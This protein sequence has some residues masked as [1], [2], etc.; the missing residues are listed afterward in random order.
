LDL[1]SIAATHDSAK[2]TSLDRD[3]GKFWIVQRIADDDVDLTTL[4]EFSEDFTSAEGETRRE[5]LAKIK[6]DNVLA[7]AAIN[8]TVACDGLARRGQ[9]NSPSCAEVVS[10]LIHIQSIC[11]V[12]TR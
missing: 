11:P 9:Q 1:I 4:L 2:R 6:A 7:I 8:R 3:N 5:D 12:S 10:D